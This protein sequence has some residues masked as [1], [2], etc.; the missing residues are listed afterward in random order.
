MAM[1]SLN[2]NEQVKKE[3]GLG[4]NEHIEPSIITS[5]AIEA[6]AIWHSYVA[7]RYDLGTMLTSEKFKDSQAQIYLREAERFIAAGNLLNKEFGYQSTEEDEGRGD[8]K[9]KR[10]IDMLD[11][12]AKN[13]VVLM[14][15][16]GNEFPDTSTGSRLTISGFPRSPEAETSDG[17]EANQKFTDTNDY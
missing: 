12:I 11:L 16:D 10:G 17:K 5:Y 15:E 14:D 6:T 8:N 9:L 1:K 13:M 3:A 2:T 7:K 4:A